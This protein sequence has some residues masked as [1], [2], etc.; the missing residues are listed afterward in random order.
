MEQYV[1]FL[2]LCLAV[3]GASTLIFTMILPVVTDLFAAFVYWLF[4]HSRPG[5]KSK[6]A[7][8]DK[9]VPH[10]PGHD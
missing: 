1:H 8:E 9:D 2:I 3:L 10:I 6:E 7:G 5:P 4:D